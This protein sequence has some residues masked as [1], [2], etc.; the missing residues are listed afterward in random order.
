[1]RRL[2]AA[3]V[4]VLFAGC[5]EPAPPPEDAPAEFVP[6]VTEETVA[7]S[8]T[9]AQSVCGQGA[10]FTFCFGGE[11]PAYLH[12]AEGRGLAGGELTLEWT[13]VSPTTDAL[14]MVAVAYVDCPDECTVE[15]TLD[16]AI[17]PSPLTM[18]LAPYDLG[19]L[20]IGIQVQPVPFAPGTVATL[21]QDVQ[22]DGVLRFVERDPAVVAAEEAAEDDDED[23][24][25]EDDEDEANG[26]DNVDDDGR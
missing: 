17:G 9:V 11:E 26:R 18:G 16:T 5:S 7:W 3:L 8:A 12:D 13:P 22:L 21:E 23:D 1:M 6:V 14:R 25:H 4:L 10:V 15:R 2:V 20:T 24:E 19:D